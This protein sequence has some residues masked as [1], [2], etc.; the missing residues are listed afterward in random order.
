MLDLIPYCDKVIKLTALCSICKD[1]TVAIFS[2]RI[3][4]EK[5]QTII[6]S[7]N[8]IPVCRTCH[9]NII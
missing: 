8:Y 5:E 3:T 7:D 9:S 6:G 2:H 4:E 1:G